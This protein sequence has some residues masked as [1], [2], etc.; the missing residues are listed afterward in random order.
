MYIKLIKLLLK[1]SNY[2]IKKD[3][4]VWRM[5]KKTHVLKSV[6]K[7]YPD[8]YVY[9]V[10]KRKKLSVHRIIYAEFKGKLKKGLVI[11]HKDGVKTN[12]IPANLE[13]ITPGENISHAIRVLKQSAI[14]HKVINLSI[15]NKIREMRK[16][17]LKYKEIQ[18]HYKLSKGHISDI[19]SNKIWKN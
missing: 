3:G 13:L 1:D 11:N 2:L 14:R 18:I 8:G 7:T 6:N 12:N 5:C 10:Y 9:I 19:I 4:T 15:A 16:N 17:G